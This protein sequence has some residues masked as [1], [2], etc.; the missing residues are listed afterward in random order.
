MDRAGKSE[1]I[2]ALE[3]VFR[4]SGAVIVTHYAGLTVAEM[5]KLRG[6]LRKDGAYFKVVK[7]TLATKAL[8][9]HRGKIDNDPATAMFTGSV[10]LAFAP[11]AV[12]AA[13]ATETFAKE[14]QKLVIIGGFMGDKL[15]GKKEVEALAKLPSLDQL[16]GQLIGLLQA[17]ATKVAGVVQAPA[18][19]LARVLSAYANKDAA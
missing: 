18:S 3:G 8:E 6:L 2:D 17:P 1:A 14:N 10:G 19:Q 5:T 11:D 12:S 9:K 7:N 13:K 15:L 4:D 16:R